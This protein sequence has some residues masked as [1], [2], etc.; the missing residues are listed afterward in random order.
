MRACASAYVSAARLRMA[1]LVKRT[2]TVSASA[3]ISH[4]A[5]KVRRS[6]PPLRRARV[7]VWGGRGESVGRGQTA[8]TE[9]RRKSK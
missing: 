9:R 2:L 7:C 3:V 4:S 6:T 1:A 8:R 5:L